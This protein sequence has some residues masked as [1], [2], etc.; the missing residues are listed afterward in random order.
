MPENTAESSAKS[1][2]RRPFHHRAARHAGRGAHHVLR[3]CGSIAAVLILVVLVGI[4]RLMQGPIELDWLTPY[5]EAAFARSETG[6]RVAVSGVRFGL[7]RASH[8]LDLRLENVRVSS[9]DGA[10]LASF[11]EMA[12]SFGL[13]ALLHGRLAPS[14]VVVEKPIF[15]LLREP[16]GRITAQVGTG[17]DSVTVATPPNLADLVQLP[18]H[19]APLGLLYRV[20]IRGATVIV[21]DRHSGQIW[22]ANRVDIAA[23]RDAN[24]ITGDLSFTV[25]VAGRNPELHASY[26][27]LAAKQLLD[28]NIAIDGVQPA[29]IP[30][31]I[32][33]L[34]QLQ[35]VDA[36]VSGTLSTR[37]DVAAWHAKGSR[38]DLTLGQGQLHSEWLPTGSIDVDS[39]EL[40]ATYA[41]E[42]QEIHLE[43]LALDL[44]GGAEATLDGT[45]GGVTS[46]L[47]NAAADNRPP[48]HLTGRFDAAL[49]HISMARLGALWPKPF[50]PGGRRWV[51]AN[52]HEGML[53]E[54]ALQLGVDLD[55]VTHAGSAKDVTGTLHYH[56]L[57]V[58]YFNGL[59]AARKLAGTAKFSGNRLE[60]LPTSGVV[61]GL[62]VTGGSLLLSEIGEKT[63]WLTADV[64]LAGPLQDALEVIDSKPL[65]YAHQIGIDPTKVAGKVDAQLHFKLP[66]IADVPIEQV[67]YTAKATMTGAKIEKAV[68]DRDISD[69][70]LA[71]DLGR[72]GARVQGTLKF[73]GIPSKVDA[74]MNFRPKSGPHTVYRVGMT[75]D[76]EAQRRFGLDV[77]PDRLSGPIGVEAIYSTFAGYRGE[78]TAMLDLREA[79]LGIA[80]A[81]WKKPAGQAATAKIALDLDDDRIT[82]VPQIEVRAAGLDGHFSATLSDDHKHLDR[83]DIQRLVVGETDVSGVVARRAGGGWR[84]DIRAAR[85][86]ARH[87]IKDSTTAPPSASSPPLAI[88]AR[89]D[90]L[91][92][93]QQR[94]LRS[95]TAELLRTGG[96]W[97]SGQINGRFSNGRQLALRFGENGSNHLVLQADDLGATL[98]LLDVTDGIVGGTL[99]VDGQLLQTAGKRTLL[100]HVEGG[101]YTLVRAPVMARILA[102]PS[103]TGIA[104]TLA[105]TGLPFSTLEGDFTYS[106]N[107][108]T[109][110]R[111]LAYGE[112]LG[113]TTNGWVDVDNDRL[114]IEGTVAPAYALN[115][116]IGH[117]P[118]IGQIFA[119]GSQGLFA[120]NYRLTG[121]TA[122]PTVTVNPL[123]ALAPGI[124]RKIFAPIVGVGSQQPPEQQAEH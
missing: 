97:Q 117:V 93:G 78:V 5:V 47:L 89:I 72:T 54:A 19:D 21:D 36:P 38:L 49:K 1:P 31:L 7:D 88:N 122:D 29:D 66:L 115:S 96:V 4:W 76:D 25:P 30:P 111:V 121:S 71:L 26:N 82:R 99:T 75:L 57:A 53:D 18:R 114:D 119:G 102:L 98:Q 23:R 17:A 16:G 27:Y 95:V 43:K 92:F 48:G 58:T 70:N 77:A 34:A 42:T 46:E 37:I 74:T 84:A 44:G 6:L 110:D 2:R 28:L 116:F 13:V 61:K 101:N 35:H 118:I 103:L 120:A 63:E 107:R 39:G 56:D 85:A 3:W 105:G 79:T 73:D 106:G 113:V 59:P 22:R 11:P 64:G 24:G 83:V 50:S 14:Q 124:L 86:D 87:L 9:P 100:A 68:L 109:L 40:H 90:R 55:P 32:P 45:L 8:Q 33:E 112:A 91:T 67:E 60:F 94:E 123:S 104:S 108:V 12:T 62:K 10:P 80:E 20:S 81:D 69:G 52:V 65:A 15:H 41:P 51:M